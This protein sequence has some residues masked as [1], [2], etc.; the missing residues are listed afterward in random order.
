[1]GSGKGRKKYEEGG[2][3][4]TGKIMKMRRKKR[5]K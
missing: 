2:I 5:G 1:M 3:E 4:E